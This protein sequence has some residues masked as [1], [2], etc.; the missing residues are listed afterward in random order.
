M[1]IEKLPT[2]SL[3]LDRDVL[4]TN[5]RAMTERMRTLG[6]QLRPHMKTAKSADVARLALAGNF[7][8]ITVSTLHEAAYFLDHG[9]ANVTYAVGMVPGR[10]DT[11]A[12]LVRRGAD[13]K[14]VTDNVDVA[15]A[16]ATHGAPHKVLIEIDT[17]DKRGGV[18][19]DAPEVIE[20]SQ[21]LHDAAN[22]TLEGVLTHAG[23]SYDR[24]TPEAIAAV[25][26]EERA[27]AVRAAERL[28]AVKIP[29][30]VV[31]VGS[32]PTAAFARDLSG[33]TEM[34]PG[35]YMFNDLFQA[36][37]GVCKLENI[38]VSVLASV[39]GQRRA[40]NLLLI[41]AGAL[42]LSKDRST[43]ELPHD[44]GYG[45][46]CDVEDG[47][48]IPGLH[49]H[50]VNQEHGLVTADNSI[51]FE[52]FPVGTKVR[53]LPNHSCITA[54]AYDAYQVIDGSNEVVATWSRCNGW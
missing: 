8:G 50:T 28:R 40:D 39:I 35:V 30:P 22:V 20:I 17:G 1:R 12:E 16:I 47:R 2:P 6:V 48:P 5:T 54:A 53:V 37:I 3:I 14:M 41:D 24:R 33:V 23:H 42:A 34:R 25:A 15:R 21:V 44:C 31:S 32:T 19:P 7:G 26:E 4:V 52:A 13:L 9:I 49:V 43:A 45:L 46:V 38:A 36:G 10:L 27:G 18:S 29:C 51:A 11:A